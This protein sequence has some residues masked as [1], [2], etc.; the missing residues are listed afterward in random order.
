MRKGIILFLLGFFIFQFAHAEVA[1]IDPQEWDFGQVKQGAI[2]KH[3]FILKNETNDI[4]GI[5]N[6]HT[7]CGCTA[8][9]SDKKSLM[10]QESTTIKVTF[11]SKGYLGSVQQFV[12][13]NTDNTD[14]AIIKFTIKAQVAKED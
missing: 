2:L 4:L 5:N 7:S 3:D 9:E 10:P 1:K 13:V 11:N 6:I 14:L 8:S 12:Y